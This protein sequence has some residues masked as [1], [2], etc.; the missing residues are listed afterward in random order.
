MTP[1]S[2]CTSSPWCS[3]TASAVCVVRSI[4]LGVDDGDRQRRQPLAERL[5]LLA[6]GV[7]EVDPGLAPGEQRAGLRGHRVTATSTHVAVA[8]WAFGLGVARRCVASAGRV[9]GA[10]S[11]AERPRRVGHDADGTGV[12]NSP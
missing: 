9:G 10:S 2:G 7:G 8:A 1:G 4:G 5:G 3:A 11:V 12:A 6:P